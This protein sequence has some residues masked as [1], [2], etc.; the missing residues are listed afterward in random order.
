MA[1]REHGLTKQ[2]LESLRRRLQ[3]ERARI[4]QVLQQP[5]ATT[6]SDDERTELAE[7][8]QRVTELTLAQE[9]AAR[10]RA[11]LADVDRALAKLAAG[12]YGYS[13]KT[14]APIPYERLAA[15]PWA[16]VGSNEDPRP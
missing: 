15:V 8:A 12:T 2:Q 10:E 1:G 4:L 16:R 14:G 13:E 7:T 5:T 3:E 9:V 6:P 11:L